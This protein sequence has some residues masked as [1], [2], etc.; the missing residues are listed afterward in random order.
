LL[1]SLLGLAAA[2]VCLLA[3][4]LVHRAAG[5][6]RNNA[7]LFAAFAGGV[8]VT[9][10]LVHLIP[11]AVALRPH[12]PWLVLAGFA[13]GFV[14]HALVSAAGNGARTSKRL[15][16]LTPVLAI[17]IHSSLDGTV[18]AVTSAFDAFTAL[19]TALGLIIHE[20]PET[21]I[22]FILLQRA[23]LSDRM[24]TLFAFLAAGATTLGA[25]LL[26]APF[27][28]MLDEALLGA[29]FAI[30]AGLLLHVGASHLLSEARDAGWLKG[31]GAVFAG[32]GVASVM[33]LG[34]AAT[35]DHS[36]SEQPHSDHAHEDHESHN[37][38]FRHHP[39]HGEPS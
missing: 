16:A 17:A 30:V 9:L 5:F 15:S 26:A 4:V 1:S 36:H 8:V 10:A 21:L 31:T 37:P 23:G 2:S 34:H 13:A 28:Q 18:Y 33:A 24:A 39:T 11:E 29:L 6:T 27:A 3:L 20:M 32:A 19:S 7:P 38:D 35:H 14:L 22:C 12:A 25:A